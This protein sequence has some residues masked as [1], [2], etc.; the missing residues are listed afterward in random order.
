VHEVCF[1][2]IKRHRHVPTFRYA[3][4][5]ESLYT[6]TSAL[7]ARFTQIEDKTKLSTA[8]ISACLKDLQQ[9]KIV[10]PHLD[11]SSNGSPKVRYELVPVEDENLLKFIELLKPYWSEE[12]LEVFVLYMRLLKDIPTEWNVKGRGRPSALAERKV[13]A[14]L[15]EVSE[16]QAREKAAKASRTN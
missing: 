10:V 8:T 7:P 14:S 13:K 5:L 12:K 4:K 15:G 9:A 6:V 16:I 3:R 2:L 11:T 1:S